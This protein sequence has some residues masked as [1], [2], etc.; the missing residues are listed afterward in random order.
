MNEQIDGYESDTPHSTSALE[1]HCA[2]YQEG[3]GVLTVPGLEAVSAI[4]YL[5]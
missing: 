5:P 2:E 3:G 1:G 4:G